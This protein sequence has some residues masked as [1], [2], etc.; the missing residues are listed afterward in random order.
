MI[1]VFS[2]MDGAGKST[3][4]DLVTSFLNKKKLH[5]YRVWSRGGYTKGFD[6][7]KKILRLFFGKKNLPSGKSAKRDKMFKNIF[8]TRF[9]IYLAIIDL[10]ILYGFVLRYKVMRG[11]V[12]LCDRYIGDTFIDFSLNFP[13][14]KVHKLFL[15]KLLR[16]LSP[17]PELSFLFLCSPELSSKRS[18]I[19]KEPFPDSL[20]A[21]KSRLAFYNTAEYFKGSNWV[22]ID[23]TA[24]IEKNFNIIN[25]N[26]SKLH[27]ED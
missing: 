23:G 19:K 14:V 16:V 10:I 3:Q 2:G 11:R 12:V 25:S 4:I 27:Y 6:V 22:I 26:L 17:K 13:K 15:W 18:L 1:I 8:V 21:L 9:W 24:S 5:Y 20:D 7:L